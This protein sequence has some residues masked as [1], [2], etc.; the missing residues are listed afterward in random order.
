MPAFTSDMG[1]SRPCDRKWKKF[2]QFVKKNPKARGRGGVATGLSF[3]IYGGTGIAGANRQKLE[4][5]GKK[6]YS[7]PVRAHAP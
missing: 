7:R 1:L 6:A 4:M 2:R 5:S 3:E